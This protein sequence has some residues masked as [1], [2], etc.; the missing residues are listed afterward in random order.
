MKLEDYFK[1]YIQGSDHYL[2]PSDEFKK[3]CE[4]NQKLNEKYNKVKKLLYVNT[5]PENIY[6]GFCYLFGN[7]DFEDLP[8]HIQEVLKGENNG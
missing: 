7:Y 5:Y 6:L 8:R 4:E 3:L 1:Y 2:I